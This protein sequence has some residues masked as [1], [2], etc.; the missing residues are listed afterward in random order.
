[1]ITVVV[2][3]KLFWGF[4]SRFE[5]DIQKLS[6]EEQTSIVNAQIKQELRDF[7]MQKNL[8]LL[9]EESE[10]LTLH[11]HDGLTENSLRYA[12]DHCHTNLSLNQ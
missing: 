2:S 5:N 12:C 10:K 9:V 6:L 7:F 1:M 4:S 11:L 8:Q 3:A